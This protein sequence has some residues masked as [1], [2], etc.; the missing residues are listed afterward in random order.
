MTEPAKRIPGWLRIDL[1]VIAISVILIG[2]GF[3][4]WRALTA[5]H[6]R[7]ARPPLTAYAPVGLY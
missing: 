4:D 7:D 5:V 2:H 3:L 6:L 1:A